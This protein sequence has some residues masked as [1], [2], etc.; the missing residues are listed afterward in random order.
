MK[1][2]KT[3]KKRTTGF[4]LCSGCYSFECNPMTMSKKFQSKVSKR[5]KDGLCVACGKEKCACK[6][7]EGIVNYRDWK[8]RKS[9]RK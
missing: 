9:Y 8:K 2:V 4:D 6:S 3:R 7:K 5:L 1:Q